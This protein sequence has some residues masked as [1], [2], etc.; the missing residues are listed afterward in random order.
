[1]SDAAGTTAV[2]Y[3][4]VD[5]GRVIHHG[6]VDIGIADHVPVHAHDRG[7]IGKIVAAPFTAH[8]ADAHV[9][10]AIV[11]AAIVA[12][13]RAPVSPVEHIQATR[14]APVRRSPQGTLVRSRH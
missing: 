4:V 2:S 8:E 13:L 6:V 9:A 11:H 14:P 1:M 10:E 5:D 3:A 7:V 12:H